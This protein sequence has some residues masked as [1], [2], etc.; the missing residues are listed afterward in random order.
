M[1]QQKAKSSWGDRPSK[2]KVAAAPALADLDKFVSGGKGQTKRLNVEIPAELHTR[3]K[4]RCAME[5]RE[6]RTV[7]T[8]LLEQRFPA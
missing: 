5:G 8:E 1:P 2:K 3:V 6:I 7:V 4:A